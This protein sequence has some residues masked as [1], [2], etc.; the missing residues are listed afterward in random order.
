ERG[1]AYQDVAVLVPTRSPVG[2][3][4]RALDAA[5]IPYRIESRSLVWAT[6]AVRDLLAVLAAIEDSA[7]EVAVVAALRTPAFACSDLELVEWRAAGGRWDHTRRFPDEI[8][9]DH[10]VAAAM[11][12]LRRWHH[13]R[14]W[15]TVDALLERVVRERD[16]VELTFAQRRPRDHWR[17][18]RFLLD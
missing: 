4:E 11:D 1:I 15:S 5:D 16:V 17:R 6:D 3:L 14:H 8:A 2:Q 12:A 18:V 10:P 13:E 9:P 7:D